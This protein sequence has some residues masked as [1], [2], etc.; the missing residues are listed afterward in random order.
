M[1]RFRSK[2]RGILLVSGCIVA[3]LLAVPGYAVAKGVVQDVFITNT[4]A[5]PV[6]VTPQ[7]TTEV[8]GTV[9]VGN[10]ITG[11][12]SIANPIT[13]TVTV[14]NPT[15]AP[16]PAPVPVQGSFDQ[17]PITNDA[18]FASGVLYEVPEGK[19]LV[20]EFFQAHWLFSGV[21]VRQAQLLVSCNDN[22][23]GTNASVFLDDRDA[24][25]GYQVV[26]GE[27]KLHVP[28]GSCLQYSAGTRGSGR[29]PMDHR[30]RQ[31]RLL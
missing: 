25:L 18:P 29:I 24:G 2:A 9:S 8:A 27:T 13:G 17:E 11:T 3:G 1:K 6:P 30:R 4:T 20:V 31:G 10:P 21:G 22:P 7:G 23:P 5:N 16:P 28:G 15:P 14:A 12:V 19:L 26:G